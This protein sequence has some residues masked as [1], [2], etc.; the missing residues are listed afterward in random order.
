MFSTILDINIRRNNKGYDNAKIFNR[1]FT[2]VS[3]VWLQIKPKLQGT[4]ISTEIT[5]KHDIDKGK[6]LAPAENTEGSFKIVAKHKVVIYL[7]MRP[8]RGFMT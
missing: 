4:K 5:G 6:Q 7:F 2:Y 3:P 8:F 1:K